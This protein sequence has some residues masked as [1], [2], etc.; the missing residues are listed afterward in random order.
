MTTK[1]QETVR[2]IFD[3]ATTPELKQACINYAEAEGDRTYAL[4]VMTSYITETQ[5]DGE[6][7]CAYT[8]RRMCDRF[9][10]ADK[11]FSKAIFALRREM[12]CLGEDPNI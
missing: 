8:L 10:E 3:S 6:E 11:A 7:V 9:D 1:E 2:A 4:Y 12:P 5:A